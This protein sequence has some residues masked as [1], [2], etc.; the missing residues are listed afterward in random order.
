MPYNLSSKIFNEGKVIRDIAEGLAKVL[1]ESLHNIKAYYIPYLMLIL[2][3]KKDYMRSAI[4][5]GM[6]PKD[7]KV[8][9]N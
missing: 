4:E 9:L 3:N 7:I 8:L 5:S 1:H 6:L 2:S